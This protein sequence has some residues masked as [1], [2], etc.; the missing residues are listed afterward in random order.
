MTPCEPGSWQERSV[1]EMQAWADSLPPVRELLPEEAERFERERLAYDAIRD[2][3]RLR[4]TALVA[5]LRAAEE[6]RR[7][8]LRREY[9]MDDVLER[10]MIETAREQAV[11]RRR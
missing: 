1:A 6:D 2:R 8:G 4:V 5:S 11:E 9:S 7:R 10:Q 3:E